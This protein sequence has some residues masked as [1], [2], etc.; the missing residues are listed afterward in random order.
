MAYRSVARAHA[1]TKVPFIAL[2]DRLQDLLHASVRFLKRSDPKRTLLIGGLLALSLTTAFAAN[3]LVGGQGGNFGS[4][5]CIV[6]CPD[7]AS[8]P[9]ATP[10]AVPVPLPPTATSAATRSMIT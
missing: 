2:L 9:K 3:D 5:G 4:G 6:G 8:T 1:G 7:A 10:K